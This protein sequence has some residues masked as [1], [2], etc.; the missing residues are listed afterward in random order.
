MKMH[1][2][3]EF[4]TKNFF[5]ASSF[6]PTKL[7]CCYLQL[8]QQWERSHRRKGLRWQEL[9]SWSMARRRKPGNTHQV[10]PFKGKVNICLWKRKSIDAK[11]STNACK[12]W[13]IWN[14]LYVIYLRKSMAGDPFQGVDPI[15]GHGQ[16]PSTVTLGSARSNSPPTCPNLSPPHWCPCPPP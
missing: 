3:E 9:C 16:W 5:A 13:L 12:L 14:H 11:I 6:M 15:L 7:V 2:T 4:D 1:F 8:G 10:F